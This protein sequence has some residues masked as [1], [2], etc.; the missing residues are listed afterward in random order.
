MSVRLRIAVAVL[1]GLAALPTQAALTLDQIMAEPDWIGAA[2]ESP[3]WSAD[4]ASV[5]Y[6]LK[7]D[8]SVVRDVHRVDPADGKDS[9]LSPAELAAIDGKEVAYD[10]DRRRARSCA[11]GTFSSAN[12]AAA[13]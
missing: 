9:V 4:G 8:G 7:R 5:Y 13:G 1:T 3:Y 11:T 6:S 2:V 12:S 10:T